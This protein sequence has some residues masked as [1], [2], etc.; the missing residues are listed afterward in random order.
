MRILT[1][2]FPCPPLYYLKYNPRYWEITVSTLRD[3]RLHNSTL[4]VNELC[5]L[6]R[7]CSNLESLE[8]RGECPAVFCDDTNTEHSRVY[9]HSRAVGL[10]PT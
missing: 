5:I 6:L 3:L 2:L 8:V 7:Q 4:T 9:A 10:L 1:Y